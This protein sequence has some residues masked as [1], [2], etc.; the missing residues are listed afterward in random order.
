MKEAG[1]VCFFLRL[2]T[3]TATTAI[4]TAATAKEANSARFSPDRI[5]VDG[6]EDGVG[7]G[8]GGGNAGS[9]LTK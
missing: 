6:G 3:A 5:P 4:R 9:V 8:V 1:E 7:V 2:K